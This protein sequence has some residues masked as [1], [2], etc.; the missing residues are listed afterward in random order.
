M[1][2]FLAGKR[3]EIEW[4]CRRRA[5]R[6]LEAFGSVVRGDFDQ[7]TS[8]IDFLVEF[9]ST[10]SLP[11]LDRYFGLK[12]D[13]ESL[14][15]RPVDLVMPDAVTNPYLRAEIERDRRLLYAA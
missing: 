15:G 4:V 8:D 12:E 14:L 5:V 9:D 7:A 1:L 2:P 6:R 11:A 13:L 3:A 10:S